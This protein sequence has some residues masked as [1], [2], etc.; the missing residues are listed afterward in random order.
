ME[1]GELYEGGI[2]F[3]LEK[4]KVH[5]KVVSIDNLSKGA[6]WEEAILLCKK[7][8]GGNKYGWHLP[9]IEE[10]EDVFWAANES[11][12]EKNYPKFVRFLLNKNNLGFYGISYWSSSENWHTSDQVHST[13]SYNNRNSDYKRAKLAVRAIRCF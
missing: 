1:I 4:D 5:G 10:L 7:Y 2:I 12:P 8:R 9:S 11:F 3:H 6:T 13:R